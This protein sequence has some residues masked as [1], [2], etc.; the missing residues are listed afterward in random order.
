MDANLVA[1]RFVHFAA[2][3]LLFGASLFRLYAG[4]GEAGGQRVEAAFRRWLANALLIA[5]I[6]AFLSALA[7]WDALAV[8]MGDGWADALN[9]GTLSAVL[10]D[11]VFG[12]V[13]IWRLVI[14]AALIAVLF[15]ARSRVRIPHADPLVAVLSFALLVTLAA[16][17]HGAM[18]EGAARTFHE[19]AQ[20][21][22]LI[23]AGAWIGALV[24]L[25]YVL[26][27]AALEGGDW[28]TFLLHALPRFSRLGYF[29]VSFLLLSGVLLGGQMIG[30]LSGLFGTSYGRTVLVK[31]CLFALM[32]A[33]ALFNRFDLTPR[34]VS[35]HRRQKHKP[36]LRLFW[37]SVLF[38]QGLAL[39]ALMAASIL[40]T[41]HP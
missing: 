11:T 8:Y 13:W 10:F 39:A 22:H 25:G 3:M 23:A 6:A 5:A 26:G 38:E 19:T 40:G 17:G 30:G 12:R 20:A 1:T 41:L 31:I 28:T 9:G 27:K 4:A 7:W 2:A 15:A 32:T 33:V 34:I 14:G 37:R 36:M 18:H 21:I 29:A 35:A 16:V 24:P